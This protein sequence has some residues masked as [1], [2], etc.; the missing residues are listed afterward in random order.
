MFSYYNQYGNFYS[1]PAFQGPP[2]IPF[3][4]Q[5]P[6]C[7]SGRHYHQ[8]AYQAPYYQYVPTPL[9]TRQTNFRAQPIPTELLR[10]ATP[11]VRTAT[12]PAYNPYFRPAAPP[13]T[14]RRPARPQPSREVLAKEAAEKEQ[15]R[16]KLYQEISKNLVEMRQILDVAQIPLENWPTFCKRTEEREEL[17]RALL[18]DAPLPPQTRPNNLEENVNLRLLALKNK[19][20]QLQ[21][22]EKIKTRLGTIERLIAVLQDPSASDL[23]TYIP[24]LN[25]IIGD[26]RNLGG[27]S[28]FLIDTILNEISMLITNNSQE[29]KTIDGAYLE[30]LLFS[31]SIWSY[32]SVDLTVGKQLLAEV[33]FMLNTFPL[34][35]AT[36]EL[37]SRICMQVHLPEAIIRSLCYQA[38]VTDLNIQNRN[39]VTTGAEDTSAFLTRALE[40]ILPPPAPLP[41]P[42]FEP[43][44][45]QPVVRSIPQIE[46]GLN[47]TNAP[48]EVRNLYARLMADPHISIEEARIRCQNALVTIQSLQ[49]IQA[50]KSTI[51]F[52]LKLITSTERRPE[53]ILSECTAALSK[54]VM[55]QV[56]NYARIKQA[57]TQSHIT[58]Y[59]KAVCEPLL[60]RMTDENVA[61]CWKAIRE[62]K[63]GPDSLPNTMP[64][65]QL[66]LQ[67]T[68]PISDPSSPI[69]PTISSSSPNDAA[70]P[71]EGPTVPL[72]FTPDT[73][74]RLTRSASLPSHNTSDLITP[75]RRRSLPPQPITI[76]QADPNSTIAPLP[77]PFVLPTLLPD[78]PPTG[79]ATPSLVP[80][81]PP[82]F[83][84]VINHQFNTDHKLT[85]RAS[86]TSTEKPDPKITTRSRSSSLPP[87]PNPLDA[88]QPITIPPGNSHSTIAPPPTPRE[89]PTG[90]PPI[91]S[92]DI[93]SS[94]SASPAFDVESSTELTP[95]SSPN[96]STT[97]AA[98]PPFVPTGGLPHQPPGFNPF[99]QTEGGF[100][101]H[102]PGGNPFDQQ[103]QYGFGGQG[104]SAGPPP[105]SP[106]GGNQFDQKP[107]P[108]SGS[109]SGFTTGFGD[110]PA[111][112]PGYD[113]N[114][115]TPF[116]QFYGSFQQ[117]R[118]RYGFK[119]TCGNLSADAF[120]KMYTYILDQIPES[121]ADGPSNQ[122]RNQ[123]RAVVVSCQMTAG[124][125]RFQKQDLTPI[126][127]QIQS[128][129]DQ[130]TDPA[131]FA[132]TKK[133]LEVATLD[134]AVTDAE[135]AFNEIESTTN[136]YIPLFG[137]GN[138]P[139]DAD[140]T[141]IRSEETELQLDAK[142]QQWEEIKSQIRSQIEALNTISA[143]DLD[144]VMSA[145]QTY[146]QTLTES[147]QAASQIRPRHPFTRGGVF[148][149][150]ETAELETAFTHL[151]TAAAQ[152]DDEAT[153]LEHEKQRIE[154]LK[155]N[156]N[157]IETGILS[158][159]VEE[160]FSRSPILTLQGE[161]SQA[162]K[163]TP[164]MLKQC[165][166][167]CHAKGM[168]Q[169]LQG[170]QVNHRQINSFIKELED[171][172]Q[173]HAVRL[174]DLNTEFS[175]L[176]TEIASAVLNLKTSSVEGSSFSRESLESYR[177]TIHRL[178]RRLLDLNDTYTTLKEQSQQI[179]QKLT[180]ALTHIETLSD[181]LLALKNETTK[182]P[183]E[184]ELTRR[185]SY[186][187]QAFE[188]QSCYRTLP[189]SV[190][191]LIQSGPMPKAITEIEQLE[192]RG[193]PFFPILM[194]QLDDMKAGV[195]GLFVDGPYTFKGLNQ[196]LG[197]F[198]K[199][200]ENA[201]GL[202][203]NDSTPPSSKMFLCQIIETAIQHVTLAQG[204]E[205]A[206]DMQPGSVG[207][208]TG[209]HTDRTLQK[210]IE[211]LSAASLFLETAIKA[212]DPTGAATM[213]QWIDY[214]IASCETN[215]QSFA[216]FIQNQTTSWD[217]NVPIYLK[218]QQKLPDD[219]SIDDLRALRGQYENL[220]TPCMPDPQS[221]QNARR[222][223]DSL[224]PESR[225]ATVSDVIDA[226]NQ[227]NT[228]VPELLRAY[229]PNIEQCK[230][231]AYHDV[232]LKGLQE[233]LTEQVVSLK[234]QLKRCREEEQKD[235]AGKAIGYLDE[236]LKIN[237]DL[238]NPKS[239]LIRLLIHKM[240]IHEF[241]GDVD[242]IRECCFCICNLN[243]E[244]IR[245]NPEMSGEDILDILNHSLD[246]LQRIQPPNDQ[247]TA[248]IQE[249]L[250][251]IGLI[252]EKEISSFQHIIPLLNGGSTLYEIYTTMLPTD[253]NI[254]QGHKKLFNDLYEDM[255]TI[256]LIRLKFEEKFALFTQNPEKLRQNALKKMAYSIAVM[257]PLQQ[258]PSIMWSLSSHSLEDLKQQLLEIRQSIPSNP[259][260]ED[261]KE[262]L[263]NAAR[264]ENHYE[265]LTTLTFVLTDNTST[266]KRYLQSVWDQ[267]IQ[268]DH[269]HDLYTIYTTAM[270]PF[271]TP[272]QIQEACTAIQNYLS[273]PIADEVMPTE[274]DPDSSI[275][276]FT[277]APGLEHLLTPARNVLRATAPFFTRQVQQQAA[278]TPLAIMQPTT[279][280][281][282]RAIIDDYFSPSVGSDSQKSKEI[283]KKI[284]MLEAL[285]RSPNPIALIKEWK[286][287]L[288]EPQ[289]KRLQ[290]R[291]LFGWLTFVEASPDY[292]YMLK[293]LN[294][295]YRHSEISS[296]ESDDEK[297]SDT[298]SPSLMPFLANRGRAVDRQSRRPRE[299]CPSRP[300]TSAA[301]EPQQSKDSDLR[302]KKIK[303]LNAVYATKKPQNRADLL[304][305]AR[306]KGGNKSPEFIAFARSLSTDNESLRSVAF[307]SFGILLPR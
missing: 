22:N 98:P 72:L 279:Q 131:L 256:E 246:L 173:R 300:Q 234:L 15:L 145:F 200:I 213:I 159:L 76:P 135:E 181:T 198:Q 45:P 257:D 153:D 27:E 185:I 132:L 207:A 34:Y 262:Y 23:Q 37:C 235:I 161:I 281:P 182:E 277:L 274:E 232:G 77:P 4:P 260:V 166:A 292:N 167:L 179:T 104:F 140:Q 97:G 282:D 83:R 42:T 18:K 190:F 243:D 283:L 215:H 307:D 240:Q 86:L 236:L 151:L 241:V 74:R 53:D 112:P 174:D 49:A 248:R 7:W 2:F 121:S 180:K 217:S 71:S 13:T 79:A 117:P 158:I 183:S 113:P 245:D 204:V 31:L 20:L 290:T 47:T 189:D 219:P 75:T 201:V 54:D 146:K 157:E 129:I 133:L 89:L 118:G 46:H 81:T 73:N 301:R 186:I 43:V 82:L 220:I 168:L 264:A 3:Q 218:I 294:D 177:D 96:A 169:T 40:Q 33:E 63:L 1:N 170:Q 155:K 60:Q 58:P 8:S 197:I 209:M 205:A 252:R 154:I 203:N 226:L 253:F 225:C 184:E 202:L 162:H 304:A 150:I 195:S 222:V 175:E 84:P 231:Y 206:S 10:T 238:N 95:P 227:Q 149:Q 171:Q 30:K 187:N 39:S 237:H 29:P 297:E 56:D 24:Y 142:K 265:I 90:L 210:L 259:L 11:P 268:G 156:I 152:I 103:P 14:A 291:E 208:T 122:A 228:P 127:E 196:E 69:A 303:L 126:I 212:I 59:T 36:R 224:A 272:L 172:I 139:V 199:Q 255:T 275:L 269:T 254:S 125:N 160:G 251:R 229:S 85:R 286:R 302:E 143:T 178:H 91:I 5:T 287:L 163:D 28:L 247:V 136:Q 305:E 284:H 137:L 250:E 164:A 273:Q 48:Q 214:C 101:Q 88:P 35:S 9:P 80:S 109:N 188:E 99:A 147:A 57:L 233:A 116:G 288:S 306:R 111:F 128:E 239:D 25:K 144:D 244:S 124:L 93:L 299:S 120:K 106:T 266:A 12:P 92:T 123:L 68:T 70:T 65:P 105:F 221:L 230:G 285:Q 94:R 276:A 50:S 100:P 44:T 51:D 249:I 271:A 55:A 110:L 191:N 211:G 298:D 62:N 19:V 263:N 296:D 261:I 194:K 270:G 64:P 278:P 119:D 289:F 32:H 21:Q 26:L 102:P 108:G 61:L 148:N 67:A 87:Q 216:N 41:S 280:Q 242:K 141:W 66:A 17:L 223:K 130:S 295:M 134:A 6:A 114:A 258:I 115:Q 38:I 16:A 267:E 293:R 107:Q 165:R 138:L 176:K 192:S 78:H 193:L 52:C